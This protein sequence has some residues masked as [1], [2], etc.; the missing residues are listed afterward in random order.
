MRSYLT[1]MRTLNHFAAT[2]PMA[3]FAKEDLP[4]KPFC[5]NRPKEQ[6]Q[7]TN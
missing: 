3:A 1:A 6:A 5:L 2:A 7:Q 4:Y